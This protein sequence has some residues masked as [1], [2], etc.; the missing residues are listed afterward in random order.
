MRSPNCVLINPQITILALIG[1]LLGPLNWCTVLTKIALCAPPPRTFSQI[2]KSIRG[3]KLIEIFWQ[4]QWEIDPKLL[5]FVWFR[6]KKGKNISS[7][8]E[9]LSIKEKQNFLEKS[10]KGKTKNKQANIVFL[11]TTEQKIVLKPVNN[12]F[13]LKILFYCFQS[14][15]FYNVSPIC[16][17]SSMKRK[18][19]IKKLTKLIITFCLQSSYLI[20]CIGERQ[21]GNSL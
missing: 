20:L 4:R 1:T 16:I 5:S 14:N 6:N 11:K 8:I 2:G 9:I 15:P 7:S 18:S 19:T 12:L 21:P 13:F 17:C 3:R 10:I